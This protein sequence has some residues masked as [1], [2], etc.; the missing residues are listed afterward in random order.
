ME[1]GYK[2]FDW[3]PLD[4]GEHQTSALLARIVSGS[5]AGA[6]AIEFTFAQPLD[7]TVALVWRADCSDMAEHPWIRR[8]NATVEVIR[9]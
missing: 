7:N 4:A 3:A 2:S 9:F 5:A 8:K 6:T 1:P